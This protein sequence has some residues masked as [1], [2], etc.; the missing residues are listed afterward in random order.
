MLNLSVLLE[1][2]AR[3]RPDA[4]ALHFGEMT[5]SYGQLD[6]LANQIANGLVAGGLAVGESVALSCPNLPWFPALYYGI[7][8]AGGVVVPLNVLL[9]RDEIAY[10]LEDSGSRFY[11]CFEGTDA[12]PLG[13]EGHAGFAQAACAE[14]FVCIGAT[15]GAP[16]FA[17]GTESIAEFL[18]GQ[19]DDFRSRD[20]GAEDCAVLVYTSGTTGR[21]KGAELSHSNL[22]WNAQICGRLL[23]VRADD[24]MLT[25]LPMFHIFGQSCLMNCALM[26]GLANVLVAR[27]DAGEVL[28]QMRERSVSLFSGVPTMYW[29]LLQHDASEQTLSAVRSRMRAC[30]SG[31]SAMPVAM[32]RDFETKFGIGVL[33]G[34]GMSE[35]SPVVTFNMPGRVRKPGSVGL[36]VWG[37]EVM[38]ADQRDQPVAV[39]ERGEL[40]FRG[41]NV[42]RGYRNRPEATAEA[43]RGGWMHSGDIA[44]MDEDGYFYIVDREKDMILRGG[45]NV[46]PREVEELMMQHPAVSL[47]AVIGVPDERYGEEIVAYV[48]PEA[49]SAAD[50]AELVAW[51]KERIAAYKYPRRVEFRERLP[52]NATGKILKRALRDEVA[53]VADA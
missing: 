15:L 47:V 52:M 17:E 21:P 1:E 43:L 48:V 46:Y 11:F 27:F 29:E 40:L 23:E 8:K 44:T 19:P 3:Q 42:M 4:A 38:V 24:V 5:L 36:P 26:H 16:A 2:S 31:G 25:A 35:G 9:K 37:V 51:T 7:L 41:H 12:L 49:G 18:A 22:A 13:A 39:G 34:Y 6:R 53:G 50:E 14:R 20:T 10:H 28:A 45:F 30:S 32:M 33:E